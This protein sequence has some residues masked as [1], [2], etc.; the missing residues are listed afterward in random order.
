MAKSEFGARALKYLG[1]III[2]NGLMTDPDKVEAIR[3]LKP[4]STRKGLRAFL[5][6]AGYYRKFV[7]GFSITAAPLFS[8]LK[9][10]NLN[11]PFTDEHTKAFNS[12]KQALMKAPVLAVP[13]FDKDFIVKTDACK[14]GL[15]GI[16]SQLDEDG[17][18]K[19]I[20]YYS[21]TCVDAEREYHATDL[22]GLAACEAIVHWDHILS[23]SKF[24][25]ITDHSALRYLFSL[26]KP[27]Q[28]MAR[29]I[30]RLMV[31]H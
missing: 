16:L 8:L 1:H 22:E 10:K 25:L 20:A 21:R 30:S 12:L 15:A 4:P 17:N 26:K 29:I 24:K 5:G 3:Q 27:R 13:N 19:P 7:D 2:P 6:L 18:E 14:T 28:K 11:Q 23:H 31:L 9:K